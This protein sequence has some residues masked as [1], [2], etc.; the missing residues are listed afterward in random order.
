MER[1]IQGGQGGQ[2]G[3]RGRG[4]RESGNPKLRY[5][6]NLR[7]RV[8]RSQNQSDAAPHGAGR[9]S[10]CEVYKDLAPTGALGSWTP[11]SLDLL[12]LLKLLELL[13]SLTHLRPICGSL[14][15][16]RG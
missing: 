12:E 7:Q 13:N 4:V 2:G 14:R 5:E 3:R 6:P 1:G 16:I 10:L 15:T 9:N 8:D 11:A